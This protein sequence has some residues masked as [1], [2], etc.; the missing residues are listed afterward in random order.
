[1]TPASPGP[2]ARVEVVPELTRADLAAQ[3]AASDAFVL[4]TRGE[5]WG[6]LFVYWVCGYLYLIERWC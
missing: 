1:M 6:G 2:L 4:P 3:Y 5:G